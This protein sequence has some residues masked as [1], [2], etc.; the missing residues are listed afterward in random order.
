MGG[1]VR[2]RSFLPARVASVTGIQMEILV[3]I[4]FSAALRAI[5]SL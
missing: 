4:G 1:R 3:G 5:N 2:G